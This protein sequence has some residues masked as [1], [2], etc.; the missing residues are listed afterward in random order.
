[1]K[2]FLLLA[3]VF[4]LSQAQALPLEAMSSNKVVQIDE[5]TTNKNFSSK[6][7]VAESEFKLPTRGGIL[8]DV[9]KSVKGKNYYDLNGLYLAS[10]KDEYSTNSDFRSI[11][12]G[13]DHTKSLTKA[14][15][16][17]WRFNFT[18]DDFD[19]DLETF[20]A[21]EAFLGTS[22]SVLVNFDYYFN[23]W[24]GE[25]KWTNDG[26]KHPQPVNKSVTFKLSGKDESHHL[27]TND[28]SNHSHN[29][30]VA[31][32]ID[33][34]WEG[35][36]LSLSLDFG[37][38]VHW[39]KGSI[40]NHTALVQAKNVTYS[41][42]AEKYT[43]DTSVKATTKVSFSSNG[44]GTWYIPTNELFNKAW[45]DFANPNILSSLVVFSDF[46]FASAYLVPDGFVILLLTLFSVFGSA[47]TSD[48]NA[49]ANGE[50]IDDGILA[51]HVESGDRYWFNY[52]NRSSGVDQSTKENTLKGISSHPL[53]WVGIGV[54]LSLQYKVV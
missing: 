39:K 2:V 28:D 36:H 7:T 44:I 53:K 46:S 1:M 43:P 19:L 38:W 12:W 20:A 52:Y 22:S 17:V 47:I 14:Q 3:G 45:K 48:L 33:E 49:V 4:G 11:N 31:F 54:F 13:T 8:E 40:Y 26:G 6:E 10:N 50:P 9:P 32:S 21:K 16:N 42:S 37:C 29:E 51:F 5:N 35:Y 24:N 30:A 34:K 27:V 15:N 41:F 18:F 23:L 25:K